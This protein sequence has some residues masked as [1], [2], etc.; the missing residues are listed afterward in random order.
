MKKTK[1]TGR[2]ENQKTDK[3]KW[4]NP[5]SAEN[6]KLGGRPRAWTEYTIDEIGAL[7]EAWA[8]QPNSRNLATFCKKNRVH[9]QRISEFAKKNIRFSESLAFAKACCESEIAEQTMDGMIPPLMGK[10]ALMQFGWK[11]KQ[12]VEHS[13]TLEQIVTYKLPERQ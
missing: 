5:A 1:P 10:L 13:G 4:N 7:L 6:G 12:E 2:S 9:P 11:D 3:P 8:L